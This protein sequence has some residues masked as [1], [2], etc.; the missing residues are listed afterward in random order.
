[1]VSRRLPKTRIKRIQYNSSA[2][3]CED[4]HYCRAAINS[5]YCVELLELHPARRRIKHYWYLHGNLFLMLVVMNYPMNVKATAMILM[6]LHSL[7]LLTVNEH[8]HPHA[9]DIELRSLRSRQ[10]YC[11]FW[12]SMHIIHYGKA[13][14]QA[15]LKVW[16]RNA[17]SLR[18]RLG[19]PF[20]RH[21][22]VHLNVIQLTSL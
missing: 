18:C 1:M 20:R 5:S 8:L 21:H 13:I 14:V 10:H 17:L 15:S 12:Q 19:C 3:N 16:R 7:L 22:G 9:V 4:E 11:L 2:R 6:Y